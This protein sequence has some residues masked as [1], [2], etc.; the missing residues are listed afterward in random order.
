MSV[1]TTSRIEPASP[2]NLA[3]EPNPAPASRMPGFRDVCEGLVCLAMAVL[4]MRSFFVEGY[5]IS[6]GSMAPALFGYH[7]RVV[8]PSCGLLF[9]RGVAFDDSHSSGDIDASLLEAGE[10]AVCPNCGQSAINIAQVPR[11]HGDQLLVFK[12]LFRLRPPNRWEIA[13]FHNP[14]HPG[15]A[16]VKRIVGLPGEAI[17]IVEGDVFA[18]G[19]ICRKSLAIQRAMRIPVFTSE[20]APDNPR[21]SASHWIGRDGWTAEAPGQFQFDPSR[22]PEYRQDASVPQW[23]WLAYRHRHSNSSRRITSARMTNLPLGFALPD[24]PIVQ[25]VTFRPDDDEPDAGTLFV[26]GPLSLEWEERLR[27]LSANADFQHAVSVLAR[28]SRHPAITDNYGYDDLREGGRNTVSDLMIAGTLKLAGDGQ[29]AIEM[30]DDQRRFRLVFDTGNETLSLLQIEPQVTPPRPAAAH[31]S[32]PD[33]RFPIPDSQPR[34]LRS[35]P[36]P[37]KLARGESVPFEMSV[38]DQQVLV[39][40]DDDLAFPAWTYTVTSPPSLDSAPPVQL[41]ARG[42]TASVRTLNL[43]RDIYYTP[44]RRRNGIAEPY[45]LDDDEYFVLGTIA[46][47]RSIAAAGPTPPSPPNF[48]SG[49]HSSCICQADQ[50]RC[51]SAPASSPCAFPISAECGILSNWDL[52]DWDKWVTL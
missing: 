37:A 31:T 17:Q 42:L 7:K 44:G 46:R 19:E 8:C 34:T 27:D 45:R 12:H 5:M 40:I 13:V 52:G 24:S 16:F 28:K 29:F 20:H 14:F 4:V 50:R 10:Q 23:S 26:T 41:G 25:P 18:N 22:D 43:Y 33:S 51:K 35:V 30:C 49:N 48:S 47:S 32:T 9:A 3:G 21:N 11:N 36:L 38:M 39:A 1:V 2:P 6:T 15:E